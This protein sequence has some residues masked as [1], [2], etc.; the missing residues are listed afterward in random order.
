MEAGGENLA[1]FGNNLKWAMQGSSPVQNNDELLLK[2]LRLVAN[3]N[4]TFKINA[5]NFDASVTAYLV[6]NFLATTTPINLTQDY[7][8]N[9]STTSVVASYSEDRFKI[10]S[11]VNTLSNNNFEINNPVIVYTDTNINIKSA[12][13]NIKS[14][15]IFD[16][17]GRTIAI[18][19]DVNSSQFTSNSMKQSKLPLLIKVTLQN[20]VTKSY[21]IIY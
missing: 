2:T 9:F 10:I 12:I 17:L 11:R 18:Y 14:V 20:G 15:E 21:K 16:L 19:N 13:E 5:V 4:Y 7:F 6:D 8:G 1:I 3:K